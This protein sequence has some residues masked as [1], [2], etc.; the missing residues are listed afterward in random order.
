[1]K[2]FIDKKRALVKTKALINDLIYLFKP[3]FRLTSVDG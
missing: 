1:M 2:K 3:G